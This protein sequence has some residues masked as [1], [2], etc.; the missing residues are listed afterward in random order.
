MLGPNEIVNVDFPKVDEPGGTATEFYGSGCAENG[1]QKTT[2]YAQE[3][4]VHS[5]TRDQVKLNFM[6]YKRG[7]NKAKSDECLMCEFRR[8]LEPTVILRRGMVSRQRSRR[9]RKKAAMI[10]ATAK[11]DTTGCSCDATH[12]RTSL[13]GNPDPQYKHSCSLGRSDH[14]GATPYGNAVSTLLEE[15]E[16]FCQNGSGKP[17]SALH[18]GSSETCT[19]VLQ[20]TGLGSSNKTGSSQKHGANARERGT[21]SLVD[22]RV[23]SMSAHLCEETQIKVVTHQDNSP[24]KKATTSKTARRNVTSGKVKKTGNSMLQK[25]RRSPGCQSMKKQ[26][27][28]MN[29]SKMPPRIL[30]TK[31]LHLASDHHACVKGHNST[32]PE[33]TSTRASTSCADIVKFPNYSKR[34]L[35]VAT[36]VEERNT[37]AGG[38]N[39]FQVVNSTANIAKRAETPISRASIMGDRI[40]GALI[41]STK[42]EAFALRSAESDRHDAATSSSH[43]TNLFDRFVQANTATCYTSCSDLQNC[44]TNSTIVFPSETTSSTIV[45]TVYVKTE[46]ISSPVSTTTS[47]CN[48]ATTVTGTNALS[49]TASKESQLESSVE[50]A[51]QTCD[52]DVSNDGNMSEV[53]S[54]NTAQ[55]KIQG[56]PIMKLHVNSSITGLTENIRPTSHVVGDRTA[57]QDSVKPETSGQ[58]DEQSGGQP[59]GIHSASTVVDTHSPNAGSAGGLSTDEGITTPLTGDAND[60]AGQ[61]V[62]KDGVNPGQRKRLPGKPVSCA[63]HVSSVEVAHV[64]SSAAASDKTNTDLSLGLMNNMDTHVMSGSLERL[65]QTRISNEGTGNATNEVLSTSTEWTTC[66][67]NQISSSIDVDFKTVKGIAKHNTTCMTPTVIEESSDA[68][69][70]TEEASNNTLH[71]NRFE[72]VDADN[73][74]STASKYSDPCSVNH[75]KGNSVHDTSIAPCLKQ[76]GMAIENKYNASDTQAAH[77]E[78][79]ADRNASCCGDPP[80]LEKVQPIAQNFD[81]AY[82]SDKVG[83]DNSKPSDQSLSL[84]REGLMCEDALS[85]A[86]KEE[87]LPRAPTCTTFANAMKECVNDTVANTTTVNTISCRQK[88]FSRVRVQNAQQGEEEPV[89]MLMKYDSFER[90]APCNTTTALKINSNSDVA[91]QPNEPPLS[92]RVPS[93]ETSSGDKI[94]RDAPVTTLSDD[95]TFGV[96]VN[97]INSADCPAYKT[98]TEHS[99]LDTLPSDSIRRT[100]GVGVTDVALKTSVCKSVGLADTATYELYSAKV[101][102]T[103]D[104]GDVDTAVQYMEKRDKAAKCNASQTNVKQQI[105]VQSAEKPADQIGERHTGPAFNATDETSN[106]VNSKHEGKAGKTKKKGERKTPDRGGANQVKSDSKKT[107]MAKWRTLVKDDA[108]SLKLIL[109]TKSSGSSMVT[110]P[111]ENSAVGNVVDHFVKNDE[112]SAEENTFTASKWEAKISK[113]GVDVGKCRRADEQIKQ[114][115]AESETKLKTTYEDT[116]EIPKGELRGETTANT[117][118]KQMQ[119]TNVDVVVHQQ[120]DDITLS[121][122]SEKQTQ[123]QFDNMTKDEPTLATIRQEMKRDHVVTAMVKPVDNSLKRDQITCNDSC[124]VQNASVCDNERTGEKKG[125]CTDVDMTSKCDT[126]VRETPIIDSKVESLTLNEGTSPSNNDIKRTRVERNIS[127]HSMRHNQ[128]IEHKTKPVDTVS[129]I[130]ANNKADTVSDITANNKADTVSDITANNKADTVSD[131]TANNKADTVSDI[132]ANNKADTISDVTANNK[133]DTMSDVTANNKAAHK[134]AGH[135]RQFL[136]RRQTRS[137]QIEM[138]MRSADIVAEAGKQNRSEALASCN[139]YSGGTFAETEENVELGGKANHFPVALAKE[140]D[141]NVACDCTSI[142]VPCENATGRDKCGMM[143]LEKGTTNP[144]SADDSDDLQPLSTFSIARK[145]CSHAKLGFAKEGSRVKRGRHKHRKRSTVYA[146]HH[147][148][149]SR[150]TEEGGARNTIEQADNGATERPR[151]ERIAVW[152]NS[153]DIGFEVTSDSTFG[154]RNPAENIYDFHTEEDLGGDLVIDQSGFEDTVDRT[155]HEKTK[156]GE[157]NASPM[158]AQHNVDDTAG[159]SKMDTLALTDDLVVEKPDASRLGLL[160]KSLKSTITLP[161][162]SVESAPQ[163]SSSLT[164][165]VMPTDGTDSSPLNCSVRGRKGVCVAQEGVPGCGKDRQDSPAVSQARAEESGDTKIR[166]RTPVDELKVFHTRSRALSEKRSTGADA[167][168][169]ALDDTKSQAS[170]VMRRGRPSGR[171]RKANRT[172]RGQSEGPDG[173]VTA[174]QSA[175]HVTSEEPIPIS[176]A[177]PTEHSEPLVTQTSCEPVESTA[178]PCSQIEPVPAKKIHICRPKASKIH[179][180]QH[181][182]RVTRRKYKSI[183]TAKKSSKRDAGECLTRACNASQK[184]NQLKC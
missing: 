172:A 51:A 19:D 85:I 60:F 142:D 54:C 79:N 177:V 80:I 31:A 106:L 82:T 20:S 27:A 77:I 10:A 101:T 48:V 15:F 83:Y 141:T 146:T 171:G 11:R 43:A 91:V 29:S 170:R 144:T 147:D 36:N 104:F 21:I 183:G 74:D 86:Q 107:E 174:M 178:S 81:A 65:S 135:R 127:K 150:G 40:N 24:C 173:G 35:A 165:E 28:H 53:D 69:N 157:T 30:P 103:D 126:S 129:D 138:L 128:V 184:I 155:P 90:F 93:S 33:A 32:L 84:D 152:G 121:D 45:P 62:K 34:L 120:L 64:S 18:Q 125:E 116:G 169:G 12:D 16:S 131:I 122:A 14:M 100:T 112:H 161:T 57:E 2:D 118:I 119:Q 143:A 145:H 1:P 102:I 41:S 114:I 73:G 136:K 52:G 55:T 149:R 181:I 75:H 109:S 13:N 182:Q 123:M 98:L 176:T 134:Q 3:S 108:N 124:A 22:E 88:Q 5:T 110:N 99:C 151:Q 163:S 87:L 89:P 78:L 167:D 26:R 71:I 59:A 56:L 179:T 95:A 148:K 58:T 162:D 130:T 160:I 44:V 42:P 156:E 70:E 158:A 115:S 117:T 9:R 49:C 97:G 47:S 61:N 159:G 72:E 154:K 66:C 39:E 68:N 63:E 166:K 25:W 137:T 180:K 7:E 4:C 96:K 92:L 67:S 113:A 50:Y 175:I 133:A 46:N 139:T 140:A 17:A 94:S 37:A 132:T 76:E 153:T 168:S 23:M 38:K 164:S 105:V 111:Q 8:D 6:K